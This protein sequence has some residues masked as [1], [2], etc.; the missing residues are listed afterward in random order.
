MKRL[1]ICFPLMALAL[2]SHGQSLNYYTNVRSIVDG[3]LHE[4]IVE[5]D[6]TLQIVESQTSTGYATA[7]AQIAPGINSTYTHWE[8]LDGQT[9]AETLIADALTHST[10]LS[11]SLILNLM[12]RSA[13]SLL[14]LE[15][16]VVHHSTSPVATPLA[17]PLA[18]QASTVFGI[19]GLVQARME[20]ELSGRW[21]VRRL[22]Q[23]REW[24]RV[25]LGR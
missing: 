9:P 10:T 22:V 1:L 14:A 13:A 8:S 16:L 19:R 5:N 12:A 21:L 23:R 15:Y 4:I 6:P 18:T 2:I 25:V 17:I 11:S 20:E 7:R 24:R 3:D